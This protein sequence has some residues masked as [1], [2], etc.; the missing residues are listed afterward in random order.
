MLLIG[1]F[2]SPYVRRC[3]ISAKLLGI[4]FEH[5][6]WSV[7]VDHARICGYSPLGRVPALV[8]DNGEVL[9][10]SASILD[11]LDDQAGPGRA[12]MPS[13]GSARRDVQRIVANA[14]GAAEKAR[15]ILYERIVRPVEKR[16]EPW[17]ERCR[18]QL[19]GALGQVEKACAHR[20]LGEWL[21][22][23]SMTQADI[24]CACVFTFLSESLKVGGDSARYPRLKSLTARCEELP[25]FRETHLAWFAFSA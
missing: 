9:A 16:H 10:D 25:E 11:T 20:G 12:L 4:P 19:H 7:G 5:A 2:D 6:N 14:I 21:V 18:V 24:T 8:L 22:G 23:D 3:A 1:M 17:V 13:S 15:D